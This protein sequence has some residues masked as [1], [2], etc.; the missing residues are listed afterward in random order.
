MIRFYST[1]WIPIAD[2]W[3]SYNDK[4]LAVITLRRMFV[5]AQKCLQWL[6]M[7]KA[8]TAQFE[9]CKSAKL[10]YQKFSEIRCLNIITQEMN[11]SQK[12]MNWIMTWDLMLPYAV[13][14]FLFFFF[15]FT[16]NYKYYLFG[17]PIPLQSLNYHNI[18][19]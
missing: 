16:C 12:W 1:F 4:Q 11:V 2:L 19:K 9:C 6:E 13:C 10:L 7:I 17:T 8:T 18:K 15:L 5:A 14:S 3:W